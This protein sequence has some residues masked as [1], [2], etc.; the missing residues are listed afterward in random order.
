MNRLKCLFLVLLSGLAWPLRSSEPLNASGCS[1][2]NL[3]YLN[4]LVRDYGK[5]TG[6]KILVRGGGSLWSH[7]IRRA[8]KQEPAA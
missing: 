2:S 1:I 4:D 8:S 6:Q 3:G 7:A 5:R